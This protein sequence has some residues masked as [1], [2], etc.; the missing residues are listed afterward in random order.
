MIVKIRFEDL[1]EGRQQGIA[2]SVQS[3]P[4][5]LP[6]THCFLMDAQVV[7]S[8]GDLANLTSIRVGDLLSSIFV[9]HDKLILG[10]CSVTSLRCFQPRERDLATLILS[11]TYCSSV[12]VTSNHHFMAQ[13]MSGTLPWGPT[14]VCDL[15]SSYVVVF[16]YVPFEVGVECSEQAAMVSAVACKRSNTKV[17]ELELDGGENACWLNASGTAFVASY[18][19]VPRI[20]TGVGRCVSL[21]GFSRCPRAFRDALRTSDELND[22]REALIDAGFSFQLDSGGHMFVQP[23]DVQLVR[24][25]LRIYG[26]APRASEVVVAPEFEV[27]LQ[28]ALGLV[29]SVASVYPR[30]KSRMRLDTAMGDISMYKNG[31]P[32]SY[33]TGDHVVTGR[34]TFIDL[35]VEDDVAPSVVTASTSDLRHMGYGR[36]P[37]PRAHASARLRR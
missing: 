32:F 23:S 28:E 34:R 35:D 3:A 37:N 17:I 11:D 4:A 19:E 20:R 27:R 1:A 18:G 2:T 13:R 21:W 25:A 10:E 22:C 33:V 29:S 15:D 36:N 5:E 14:V 7:D 16:Q 6:I 24:R 8:L 26:H 30:R 9:Q 31:R 12:C